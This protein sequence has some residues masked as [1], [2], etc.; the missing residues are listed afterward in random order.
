MTDFQFPRR[1][2]LEQDYR[3]GREFQRQVQ[4]LLDQLRL[5]MVGYWSAYTD[6][7]YLRFPPD[8]NEKVREAVR[9]TINAVNDGR[10]WE[11]RIT[12]DEGL[13]LVVRTR[14]A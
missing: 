12:H 10:D 1:E 14:Q 7:G 6:R 11:A 9:D 2:Q 8:T 13:V 4:D 3:N 5:N